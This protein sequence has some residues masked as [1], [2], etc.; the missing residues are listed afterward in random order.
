[1]E[2]EGLINHT[3]AA[4]LVERNYIVQK[5]VANREHISFWQT[6]R[7]IHANEELKAKLQS[8]THIRQILG[9]EEYMEYLIEQS[10]DEPLFYMGFPLKAIEFYLHLRD[11]D[12][13]YKY[14]EP[15]NE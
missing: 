9:S 1:M 14:S 7:K 5:L 12:L 6:V 13:V 8:I 3:L 10:P 11:S 4:S 2:I 15:V